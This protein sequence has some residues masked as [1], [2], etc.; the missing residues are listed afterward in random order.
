MDERRTLNPI[1][2]A[3]AVVGVQQLCA[4]YA[5]V[6]TRRAFAE[7]DELFLPDCPIEID[8]RSAEPR[9]MVGPRAFAAFV[10]P[11]M[12]RFDFFEFVVLNVRVVVE[13]AGAAHSRLYLC[14]MRQDRDTGRRSEAFGLYQDRARLVDG[15]WRF[16]ARHYQSLARTA[17]E[18]GDR[19]LEVLPPPRLR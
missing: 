10:E 16:A 8:T 12:A 11:A 17:T 4:A 14:E 13:S 7:L 5:D 3:V 1:D 18:L 15:R 19:D 6:I 9:S 2:H